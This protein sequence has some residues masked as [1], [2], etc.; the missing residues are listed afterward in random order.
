M[1]GIS[2]GWT[3]L[4]HKYTFSQSLH[5]TETRGDKLLPDGPLTPKIDLPHLAY[6]RIRSNTVVYMYTKINYT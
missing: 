6:N 2:P 1:A 4:E 3:R 5:V